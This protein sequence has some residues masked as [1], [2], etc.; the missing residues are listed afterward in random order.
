MSHS[1]LDQLVSMA[2][3]I[4]NNNAHQG[5]ETVVV[6]F[7]ASHLKRFWARSM[8][9]QIIDYSQTADNNLNHI[10]AKAVAELAKEYA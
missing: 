1:Q 10:A 5:D 2:N 4:A 3:Q 8:K 6:N 9:Q 7:V